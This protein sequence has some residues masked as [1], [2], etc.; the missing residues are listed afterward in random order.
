MRHGRRHRSGARRGRK[1]R[2]VPAVLL[3]Q[4]APTALA[5]ASLSTIVRRRPPP[6]SSTAGAH[7]S[8]NR[9]HR[10]RRCRRVGSEKPTPTTRARAVA[11]DT[12]AVLH[13]CQR[14]RVAYA[15]SSAGRPPAA[16]S[17]PALTYAA[18]GTAELRRT[19]RS[20]VRP[21]SPV[22]PA[23]LRRRARTGRESQRHRPDHDDPARRL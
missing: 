20:P 18:A 7:A 19:A 12:M 17:R 23:E 13:R 16:A 8:A 10:S 2:G 21:H 6:P 4:D 5:S 3:A 15:L 14:D 22:V 1:Y 11:A 9:A